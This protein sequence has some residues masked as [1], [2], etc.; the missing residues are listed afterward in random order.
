MIR[1]LSPPPGAGDNGTSPIGLQADPSATAT[2]FLRDHYDTKTMVAAANPLSRA[3]QYL[4]AERTGSDDEIKRKVRK[5]ISI[6]HPDNLD[7]S[8][9]SKESVARAAE[10]VQKI[11]RV[12]DRVKCSRRSRGC[13]RHKATQGT[14]ALSLACKESG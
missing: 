9:R 8:A 3:Y 11:I 12:C 7:L 5:L 4:G 6:H 14:G 10:K 2:K 1:R 13:A